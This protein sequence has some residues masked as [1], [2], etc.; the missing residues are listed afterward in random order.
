[1]SRMGNLFREGPGVSAFFPEEKCSVANYF[2]KL[3]YAELKNQSACSPD[4]LKNFLSHT[5]RNPGSP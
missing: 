3:N 4:L 2:G 5:T 1:M